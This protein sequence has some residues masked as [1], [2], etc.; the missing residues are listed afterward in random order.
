[1]YVE[2]TPTLTLT[3]V[4][5]SQSSTKVSFNVPTLFIGSKHAIIGKIPTDCAITK[6]SA[7]QLTVN[8]SLPTGNGN[9][10]KKLILVFET[11]TIDQYVLVCVPAPNETIVN[12]VENNN[13]DATLTDFINTIITVGICNPYGYVATVFISA[14]LAISSF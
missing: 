10:E 13:F 9:G 7:Q 5:D 8:M 12:D 11:N 2:R 14:H 3:F 4:D 1:V 6:Q